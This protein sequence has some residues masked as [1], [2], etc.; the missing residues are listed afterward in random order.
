MSTSLLFD[1]FKNHFIPKVKGF[2]TL[3]NRPLK[4]LLV[5]NNAASHPKMAQIN[6]DPNFKVLFFTT[7]LY[8]NIKANGSKFNTKCKVICRK[9]LLQ[10]I[11]SEN[12]DDVDKCLML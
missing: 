7:K 10:H 9:Q 2:L 4:A 3:V 11:L 5:L 6:F 8:G 12:D 1:W